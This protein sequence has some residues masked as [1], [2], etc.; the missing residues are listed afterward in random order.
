MWMKIAVAALA[1]LLAAAGVS[2]AGPVVPTHA[3]A[4]P[5]AGSVVPIQDYWDRSGDGGY[6]VQGQP[7][8]PGLPGYGEHAFG[9]RYA[10]APSYGL[11]PYRPRV[12]APIPVQPRLTAAPRPW[13]AQWYAYCSGRYRSFD[14]QTGTF[15][16]YGGERRLCR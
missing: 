2:W 4:G 7:G 11:Q 8:G 13:T 15:V 9:Y 3:F 12:I 1:A 6:G 5:G 16:T 14:R 10:P